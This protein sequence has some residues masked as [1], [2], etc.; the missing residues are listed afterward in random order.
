VCAL[1]GHQVARLVDQRE[2]VAP[3]T[4]VPVLAHNVGI[5]AVGDQALADQEEYAV[6]GLVLPAP[7]ASVVALN[8]DK[9]AAAAAPGAGQIGLEA[10]GTLRVGAGQRLSAV[11]RLLGTVWLL[12]IGHCEA[13]L[14]GR[15]IA[16]LAAIV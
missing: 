3:T 15:L 10:V 12:M 4:L 13:V 11:R 7:D 5:R 2:L 1:I 14:G 6:A 9:L 8:L 16:K